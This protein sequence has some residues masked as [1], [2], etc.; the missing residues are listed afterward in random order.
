MGGQSRKSPQASLSQDIIRVSCVFSSNFLLIEVSDN[1]FPPDNKTV[2]VCFH[3]FSLLPRPA[4]PQNP[5]PSPKAAWS[6]PS[7][8]HRCLE[9]DSSCW[10]QFYYWIFF[11]S[12]LIFY[13]S[14]VIQISF[15]HK[16]LSGKGGNHRWSVWALQGQSHG[17]PCFLKESKNV[18]HFLISG[19]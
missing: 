7:S 8:L 19:T 1:Q 11:P 16:E 15:G 10:Y 18:E 12:P 5:E 17:R 13:M 9:L 3:A 2:A 6:L 4:L 14:S